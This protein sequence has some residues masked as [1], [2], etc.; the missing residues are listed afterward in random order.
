MHTSWE[1]SRLLNDIRE[2]SYY[3]GIARKE[4]KNWILFKNTR[5]LESQK[6]SMIR[7]RELL[8]GLKQNADTSEVVQGV[9]LLEDDF[10]D[11][12]SLVGDKLSDLNA[13]GQIASFTQQAKRIDEEV[14]EEIANISHLLMAEIG[15]Q[16][17]TASWKFRE[18]FWNGCLLLSFGL[19]LFVSVGFFWFSSFRQRLR[20]LTYATQ[21][22]ALGNYHPELQSSSDEFGVLVYYFNEMADRIAEREEKINHITEELIQANNLLKKGGLPPIKYPK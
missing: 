1:Y 18:F 2:V 5:H 11:Y 19:F 21:Q 20:K 6:K 9:E 4:E 13:P 12:D 15:R 10:L 8:A 22:M 16:Q 3:F 14:V 17:M 7:V